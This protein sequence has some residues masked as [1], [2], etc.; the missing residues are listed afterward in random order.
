MK[1]L[2]DI[3]R[4]DCVGKVCKSKSSGDFK[5]VKYNNNRNVEIRFL[6]T[7]FEATVQLGSIK[8]GE[9]KD[10]YSPSVYG[11]GIL[12]TK[13]SSKINGV[14]TKEYTLWNDMLK[15]CYSD[16][17][18]KKQPTYV[19]CKCS[20]NFKSYEYF[21]EWCRKQVGFANLRWQLDKDLLGKG[22]KVY[23]ENTCVFIP[24]EINQVLVKRENMRGKYPI[25]VYWSK[26][27]KAFMARVNM[28]KGKYEYLGSFNT[29]LEAFK[30]YKTAKESFIK[31]Q[32]E[33]WKGQIDDR[34]YNAL[35][36]YQ[37]E[38]DD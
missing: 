19:D 15:R 24:K 37:V 36:N 27:N 6:K 38:I 9:V 13:Y 32:A 16:V 14:Q 33:K 2:N 29:E 28:N 1:Y 31:E 23:N 8:N 22:N 18:K 12:G 30:V 35:M 5:I 4:K 3:S 26:T 10:F 20:E 25:G 11:V 7:G 21:Y 17:Y 34:A